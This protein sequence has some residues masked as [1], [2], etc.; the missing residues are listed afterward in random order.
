MA[1]EMASE[2]EHEARISR[3]ERNV[4]QGVFLPEL[5]IFRHKIYTKKQSCVSIP[6]NLLLVQHIIANSASLCAE[7]AAMVVEI[8]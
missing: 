2:S 3:D 7:S 1:S 5:T 8:R 6:Q 4:L